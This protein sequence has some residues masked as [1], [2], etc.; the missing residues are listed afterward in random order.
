MLWEAM[1]TRPEWRDHMAQ[2][3]PRLSLPNVAHCRT[4]HQTGTVKKE[5]SVLDASWGRL[6]LTRARYGSST[7]HDQMVLRGPSCRGTAHIRS[8][9]VF[10]TAHVATERFRVSRNPL[11]M[12]VWR[13]SAVSA[14]LPKP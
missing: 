8:F 2:N 10:F 11:F 5:K 1:E 6:G 9:T 13:V 14:W 4:T 7:R 3:E 12:R